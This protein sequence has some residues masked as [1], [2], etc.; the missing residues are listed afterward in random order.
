MLYSIFAGSRMIPG[1]YHSIDNVAG[2]CWQ[3]YK[4]FEKVWI[5]RFGCLD[6]IADRDRI[7]IS[8]EIL[9]G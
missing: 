5:A 1:K 9:L 6:P 3:N 8:K 4:E 7:L 2:F